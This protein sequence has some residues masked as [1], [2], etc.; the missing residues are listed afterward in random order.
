MH[1]M[2]ARSPLASRR[3]VTLVEVMIASAVAM[4]L[5]AALAA[6]FIQITRASDAS[7]AQARAHGAARAAVERIASEV[8]TLRLDT[9]AA[10]HQFELV[11]LTLPYGDGID[12]DG[13]GL[14]DEE[15][16]DGF[17][18]DGDWTPAS[19]L[20]A[21]LSP[22][23][24]E[25]DQYRG[26]PDHGDL[27]VD[28][29]TLFSHDSISFIVPGVPRRRVS[30]RV[31][32]F[33]GEQHVLL[34]GVIENPNPVAPFGDEVIEPIAFDVVSLDILAWNANNDV[35]TP[36]GITDR[37]Y[38]VSAWNAQDKVLPLR[39]MLA[40]PGTPPFKLP[41]ALLI[42]VTVNANREP[43]AELGN[44]QDPTVPIETVRV[45]T[46]VTIETIT[47]DNRY[48]RFVRLP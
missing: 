44:W 37:P 16:F 23:L 4:L 43:L 34:R 22:G 7:Q 1:R 21:E 3:G 14:V 29:D 31:G 9:N 15:V 27:G 18:T 46:V 41:A 24:F 39:P 42:A 11:D 38:W 25:R 48:F 28:E 36:P 32:E 33:E 26:V 10:F 2:M 40:P 17:D 47:Q 45:Q 5:V 30:Y 6:A 35:I 13:D 19:D 8:R 12:N 20:H